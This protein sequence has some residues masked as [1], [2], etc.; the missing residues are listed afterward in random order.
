MIRSETSIAIVM[1]LVEGQS[2][3]QMCKKRLPIEEVIPIG[4]QIA[5]ALAYAMLKASHIGTSS[6]KT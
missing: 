2:L 3:R 5:V 4:R 1:E 6:R